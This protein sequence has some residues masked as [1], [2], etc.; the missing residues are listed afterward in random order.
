VTHAMPEPACT[1]SCHAWC[2]P[3][4][5]PETATAERAL[6][7]ADAVGDDVDPYPFLIPETDLDRVHYADQCEDC[8][9]TVRHPLYPAWDANNVASPVRMVGPGCLRKRIIARAG[10]NQ[11]LPL[12]HEEAP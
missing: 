3:P 9:R 7:A 4:L 6:A 1:C 12:I 10:Q 5:S 2:G 8:G 11:P